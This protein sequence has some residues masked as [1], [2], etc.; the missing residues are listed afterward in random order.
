MSIADRSAEDNSYPGIVGLK[1]DAK[2][3]KQ[4]NM[5]KLL[6]QTNRRTRKLVKLIVVINC[7]QL[8]DQ[9]FADYKGH[10][11]GSLKQIPELWQQDN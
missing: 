4:H 7:V 3:N 6:E 1:V 8:A 11:I 9:L 2:T 10:N 5:L